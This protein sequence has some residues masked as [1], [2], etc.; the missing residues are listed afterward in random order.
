MYKVARYAKISRMLRTSLSRHFSIFPVAAVVLI[1]TLAAFGQSEP[2]DTEARVINGPKP[3]MPAIAIEKGV[4]GRISLLMSV[5]KN[6]KAKSLEYYGPDNVC[7]Q[8]RDEAVTA[9]QMEAIVASQNA[10]YQP[11]THNGKPVK[12]TVWVYYEFVEPRRNPD[13]AVAERPISL[14]DAVAENL[15]PKSGVVDG[16]LLNSKAKNLPKPIYPQEARQTRETG[17]ATVEVLINEKGEVYSA[18]AGA[19]L[20]IFKSHARLAACNA[21]FS[22]FLIN[23]EPVKVVGY[24]KYDFFPEGMP[25]IR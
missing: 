23:G 5:D 15:A 1:M 18:E 3:M 14:E 8:I 20:A 16:G 11:A 12:S 4:Y 19:G 22:P 24:L 10:T 7:M 21:R 6:G 13:L 9:L 17:T 2:K 25:V